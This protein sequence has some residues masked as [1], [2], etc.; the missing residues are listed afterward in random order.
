MAF[1]FGRQRVLLAALLLFS[2][3]SLLTISLHPSFTADQDQGWIASRRRKPWSAENDEKPSGTLSTFTS[4]DGPF[5]DEP[6]TG[7]V[8]KVVSDRDVSKLPSVAWLR[9]HLRGSFLDVAVT[10][11]DLDDPLRPIRGKDA[12]EQSRLRLEESNN[13]EEEDDEEDEEDPDDTVTVEESG[14]QEPKD[15]SD[16][17]DNAEEDADLGQDSNSEQPDT[18]TD[19]ASDDGNEDDE[20]DEELDEEAKAQREKEEMDQAETDDELAGDDD[21]EDTEVTDEQPDGDESADDD[22]DDMDG[23][24]GEDDDEILGDDEDAEDDEEEEEEEVSRDRSLADF[25]LHNDL[26]TDESYMLFVPSGD[27]IEQQ[28]DSLVTAVWMARHANRTLLIPPPIMPS[29]TLQPLLAPDYVAQK[30]RLVWSSYYDLKTIM[31]T[32][33]IRFL[34]SV[35]HRLTLTFTDAML[36]EE[37][38]PTRPRQEMPDQVKELQLAWTPIQCHGPPTAGSWKTLDFAG[39][40]FLNAY[41]LQAEFQILGDR[42][43]DLSP[44]AIHKHWRYIPSAFMP[45]DSNSDGT[46][47]PVDER[48]RDHH[49]QLICVS[50]TNLVGLNNPEMEE[51]LWEEIGFRVRFSKTTH[52]KAWTGIQRA[53]RGLEKQDRMYGFIGVHFDKMPPKEVCHPETVDKEGNS[54]GGKDASPSSS[55][56]SPSMHVQCRWTVEMVSKRVAMLQQMEG[57]PRPVVVTTTETDPEILKEMDQR[58]GWFRIEH[59]VDDDDGVVGLFDPLGLSSGENPNDSVTGANANA[60][61][62]VSGGYAHQVARANVHSAAAVFVGSRHSPFD[63]HVAFRLKNQ[64]RGKLNPARWELH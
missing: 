64:G 26:S 56:A 24:A 28:F 37:A 50:G 10:G 12:A 4:A 30:S 45:S 1:P 52:E 7:N 54:E 43:W 35:R 40:H 58:P 22:G 21:E 6:A 49:Q 47:A 62:V 61:V 19:A 23:D 9:E 5:P 20:E 44:E 18:N 2:I 53:L 51:K 17:E 31:K 11:E 32:Q 36:Q 33:K 39:R 46:E 16:N 63:V 13:S 41:G 34:D 42:Y 25:D 15:P 60:N 48:D 27:T 55:P 57:K 3:G 14:D 38:D 59:G 29:P 8:E